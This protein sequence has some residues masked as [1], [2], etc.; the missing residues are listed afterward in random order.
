[1]KLENKVFGKVLQHYREKE[2][3]TQTQLAEKLNTTQVIISK[4]ER[5]T[6]QITAFDIL[7][8]T[9]FFDISATAFYTKYRKAIYKQVFQIEVK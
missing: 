2:T 8:I 7:I 9:E 3:L 5:G 1:M 6:Q 4:W